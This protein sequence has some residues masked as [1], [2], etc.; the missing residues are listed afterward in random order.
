M[1]FILNETSRD[2]DKTQMHCFL[3]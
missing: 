3:I 2:R 1:H